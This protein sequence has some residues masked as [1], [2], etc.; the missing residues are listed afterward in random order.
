VRSWL[1]FHAGAP[2]PRAELHKSALA[3]WEFFA[4]LERYLVG[5]GARRARRYGTSMLGVLVSGIKT[6][7]QRADKE[8]SRYDIARNQASSR[9]SS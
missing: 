9:V 3:P 2:K 7:E 5:T 8:T 4:R 1:Q 6:Q